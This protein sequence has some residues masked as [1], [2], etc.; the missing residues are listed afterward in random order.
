MNPD[1]VVLKKIQA[2]GL[3]VEL[4][5]TGEGMRVAAG[6]AVELAAVGVAVGAA[7]G[8]TG[9]EKY[10]KPDHLLIMSFCLCFS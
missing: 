5:A 7:E 10:L 2:V 3:V 1:I 9:D 6:E 4:A 8:G